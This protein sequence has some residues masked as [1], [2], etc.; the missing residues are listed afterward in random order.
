M[1]TFFRLLLFPVLAIALLVLL[2]VGASLVLGFGIG[3]RVGGGNVFRVLSLTE[4]TRVVAVAAV[5]GSF[6]LIV[7]MMLRD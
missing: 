3:V 1:N 7:L 2:A 6:A 5:V 4:L